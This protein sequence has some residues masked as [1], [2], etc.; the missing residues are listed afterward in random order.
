MLGQIDVDVVDPLRR[1]E[2]ERLRAQH[3]LEPW[4][5]K[6]A[7]GNARDERVMVRD[8]S[9]ND[10]QDA[11]RKAYMRVRVLRLKERHIQRCQVLHHNN[12]RRTWADRQSPKSRKSRVFGQGHPKL[13]SLSGPA[14][15]RKRRP[16]TSEGT[17][18]T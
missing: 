16:M 13:D 15:K 7:L 14:P 8:R 11:H 1:A 9:F 2:V 4:R 6:H 5:R 17:T 12:V 18:R 10:G 3:L